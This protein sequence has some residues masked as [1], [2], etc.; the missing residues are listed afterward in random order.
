[1]IKVLFY[2]QFCVARLSTQEINL[3]FSSRSIALSND[4]PGEPH[5][6]AARWI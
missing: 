3:G 5:F 4:C 1:M 2:N 6:Q